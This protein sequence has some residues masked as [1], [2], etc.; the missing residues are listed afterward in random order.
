MT[1]AATVGAL[2]PPPPLTPRPT[3][4]LGDLLE[5]DRETSP[6]WADMAI[7][8]QQGRSMGNGKIAFKS[9]SGPVGFITAETEQVPH[10]LR[11]KEAYQ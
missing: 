7:T 2:P 6:R 3:T 1:I 10:L 8:D 4:L 11:M 5:R 9:G